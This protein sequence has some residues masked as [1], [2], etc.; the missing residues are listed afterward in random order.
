MQIRRRDL[1]LAGAGVVDELLGALGAGR[2]VVPDLPGRLAGPLKA[3]R[4]GRVSRR[5]AQ[6]EHLVVKFQVHQRDLFLWVRV[7][8]ISM[9]RLYNV[10]RERLSHQNLPYPL[11][12]NPS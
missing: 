8:D 4:L 11:T 12:A 3:V 10:D 9:R 5:A 1:D 7:A 2:Q 6:V